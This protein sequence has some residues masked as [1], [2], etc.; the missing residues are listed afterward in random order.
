MG[1]SHRTSIHTRD[2][3]LSLHTDIHEEEGR[4]V[5]ILF[6]GGRKLAEVWREYDDGLSPQDLN[7]EIERYHLESV[8]CIE[9]LYSISARVKTVRHPVSMNKLGLMFLKWG[10][11]DE[12]ISEFELA[13]QYDSSIGELYLNLGSSYLKRGGVEEAIEVLE[14]G[15]EVSPTYADIRFKLGVAYY[16]GKL[17]SEA[18]DSFE[19][20][21]L[22]NPVY[23]E[24]H[25]FLALTLLERI[26]N[27]QD[28]RGD[29]N[30]KECMDRVREHLNRTVSISERFKTK[31][32]EEAVRKIHKGD[33]KG[34]HLLL[35]EISLNIPK[36]IDLDFHHYFYLNYIYGD[37]GKDKKVVDDYVSML[38]RLVKKHPDFPDIRNMLGIA[39]LIQCRNLY[40]K[41][42]FQF[43][44]AC[45]I[46]SKY[47]RA[48]Q[49]LRLAEN[50]GKGILIL[51]RAMLK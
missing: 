34:A 31:N 21:L 42:L 16:S 2:R 8:N 32:F 33:R 30:E 23:D 49:N 22:I 4:I 14:K 45:E 19:K 28:E 25:F 37:S 47:K 43:G 12:A 38:E 20:A 18:V 35:K 17:Y 40:M 41:S 7:A 44:K 36:V 15:V 6:D 24:A 1:S 27:N 39:Y 50:E 26:L 48:R 51:L 10:L 3:N 29:F 9:F 11:I 46:N 13:I 5:S